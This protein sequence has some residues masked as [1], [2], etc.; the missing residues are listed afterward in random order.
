LVA[1]LRWAD[2]AGAEVS[3]KGSRSA[4]RGTR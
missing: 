4:P 3:P 2:A 1:Q